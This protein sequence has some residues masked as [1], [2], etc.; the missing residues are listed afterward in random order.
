VLDVYDIKLLE[1][2]KAGKLTGTLPGEGGARRNITA[3][4]F[5]A[6]TGGLVGSSRDLIG[7]VEQY[8]DAFK[9][10]L[11]S[12]NAFRMSEAGVVEGVAGMRPLFCRTRRHRGVGQAQGRENPKSSS[13]K[14]PS[15]GFWKAP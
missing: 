6:A 14:A 12:I 8:R 13:S 11:K 4:D 3:A 1:A 7:E 9:V 10:A 2:F 15:C 5:D